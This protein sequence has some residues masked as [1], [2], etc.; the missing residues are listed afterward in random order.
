MEKTLIRFSIGTGIARLNEEYTHSISKPGF[1]VSENRIRI[2]LPVTEIG[3]LDLSEDEL[4]IYGLL[5]EGI[6]LSRGEIDL[7][8]GFEKSK[9]LRVIN[10]LVDKNIV[11]KIG[12][13]ARVTYKLK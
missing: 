3:R 2:V 1:D 6:E 7:N 11:K 8:T 10:S 13:G 4:L 9:T 12:S 5:K